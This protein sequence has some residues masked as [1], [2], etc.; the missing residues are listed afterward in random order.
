MEELM[1]SITFGQRQKDV[2]P[3]S[4]EN[5]NAYYVCDCSFTLFDMTCVLM[6]I[7]IAT[8]YAYNCDYH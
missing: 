2:P 4:N 5:P 3:D 6:A 7:G 1:A 8:Y